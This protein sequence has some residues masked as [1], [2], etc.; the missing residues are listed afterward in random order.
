MTLHLG[1]VGTFQSHT[2]HL[3]PIETERHAY[4]H[5]ALCGLVVHPGVTPYDAR[6]HNR[7]ICQACLTHT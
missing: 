7:N 3:V 5:K 6:K 1:W 2:G 4:Y